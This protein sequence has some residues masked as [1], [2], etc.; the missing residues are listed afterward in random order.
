[1]LCN[2]IL[3]SELLSVA[4]L[5]AAGTNGKRKRDDESSEEDEEEDEEVKTPKNKKEIKTPQT[6]PKANKKVRLQLGQYFMKVKTRT[7][8]AS[9]GKREII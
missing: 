7:A 8:P 9:D 5:I 4:Y 1:M 6:F 3:A 2:F